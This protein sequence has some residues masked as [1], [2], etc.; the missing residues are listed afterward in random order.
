MDNKVEELIRQQDS[1]RKGRNPNTFAR[2][3]LIWDEL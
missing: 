2:K 3:G 1:M